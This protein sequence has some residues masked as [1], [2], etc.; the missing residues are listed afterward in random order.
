M[1]LGGKAFRPGHHLRLEREHRAHRDRQMTQALDLG[2]FV[3]LR[4]AAVQLGERQ[5]EQIERRELGRESLGGGHADF[6]AGARDVGEAAFVDHGGRR[7]VADRQRLRH[8]EFVAR[9]AKRGQRIRRFARLRDRHN[10]RARIGHA[11]A[12]AV[13]A[14]DFHVARQ[15]GDFLNPVLGRQRGVIGRATGKEQQAAGVA[16][17]F[18]G[19]GAE[20][21]RR[22]GRQAFERVTHG[23][24]LLEDFL[25]HEVSVGAELHGARIGV[26]DLNRTLGLAEVALLRALVDLP[27][28]GTDVDD[29]ALDDVHDALG[30]TADSHSVGC[31]EV[32][33]VAQAKHHGRALTSRHDAVRL[34]GRN[35]GDGIAALELPD[36]RLNGLKQIAVI[37]VVD[38]MR[39]DFRIRLARKLVALGLEA[40]ADLLVIFDDAVVHQGNVVIG[41]QWMRVANF[42]RA[43][44]RPARVGDPGG[45]VN[46]VLLHQLT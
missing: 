35:D 24:G 34:V 5:R 19:I 12:V 13:F 45:A 27:R 20:Q 18:L 14:G 43:V 32:F 4:Q 23:P 42:R 26:H 31:D 1:L 28:I 15:A 9:V 38:Q 7:N 46:A 17:D 33:A 6:H 21:D 8:A 37:A 11:R 22:N 40:A 30:D 39:D 36:G 2:L 41:D 3:R 10:E 16:E 29:V 25:L 44:G